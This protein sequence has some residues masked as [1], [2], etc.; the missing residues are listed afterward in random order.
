MEEKIHAPA[1][2]EL[3][4]ARQLNRATLIAA[5]V[6]TVLLVTIV[7]PAEY[8]V[9]PVGTGRLLGLTEMGAMKRDAARAAAEPIGA[10]SED[11][12]LDPEPPLTFSAQAGEQNLTLQ[13]RQGREVKATMQ[14]GGEFD[15]EWKTDGPAVHYELHG[16]PKGAAKGVYS[17]YDI[18]ESA[19]EKGKFRAPFDGTQGWY[20][21]NDTDKPVTIN[22]KAKGTW[23]KFEL[24]PQR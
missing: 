18:G 10:D 4:S 24:L 6:A 20:W 21:R 5:G 22:V 23:A 3:P 16:E 1:I 15:Y 2:G 9:D 13:P 7:L 14:A 19:G 17:S 12:T 11:I 8:G